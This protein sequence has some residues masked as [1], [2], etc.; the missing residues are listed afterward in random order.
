MYFFSFYVCCSVSLPIHYITPVSIK[1]FTCFQALPVWEISGKQDPN[2]SF[3]FQTFWLCYYNVNN[4][5]LQ[6]FLENGI[7]WCENTINKH[8]IN[9]GSKETL[10][11]ALLCIFMYLKHFRDIRVI[12]SHHWTMHTFCYIVL[13]IISANT[14]G[15]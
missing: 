7:L 8:K 9:D 14:N 6:Y 1:F 3:L 12:R 10:T 15:S 2:P 4:S 5:V 13:F 11:F